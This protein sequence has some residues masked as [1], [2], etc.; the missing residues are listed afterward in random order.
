MTTWPKMF[1]GSEQNG[2][3]VV[4]CWPQRTRFYFSGSLHMCQFLWKSIKN[5]TTRVRTDGYTDT[6]TDAN[7]FYNL[8]HAIYSIAIWQIIMKRVDK[9]SESILLVYT[10]TRGVAVWCGDSLSWRSQYWVLQA[11]AS[12]SGGETVGQ[13]QWG[14]SPY[15]LV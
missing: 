4:R 15:L 13:H 6:L 3:R 2:R 7:R 9:V 8:F 12:L 11:P 14:G 1:S 10:R 5:A